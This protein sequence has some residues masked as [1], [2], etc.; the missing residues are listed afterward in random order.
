[1]LGEG[2]GSRCA[3]GLRPREG[4]GPAPRC[5]RGPS[6]DRAVLW[7]PGELGEGGHFSASWAFGEKGVAPGDLG[8]RGCRPGGCVGPG[9]P[10]GDAG[11]T[12]TL[13][14]DGAGQEGLSP[15]SPRL[16]ALYHQSVKFIS[17]HI[18][19]GVQMGTLWYPVVQD[20]CQGG[21][22]AGEPIAEHPV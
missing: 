16:P 1:M 6:G 9:A 18:S 3:P 11:A 10:G 13:P 17:E 21:S 8:H 2:G 12:V 4:A 22:G 14:G 7:G 15:M 19:S 20:V 5:E